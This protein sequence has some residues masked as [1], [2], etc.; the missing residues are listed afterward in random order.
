MSFVNS[1]ILILKIHSSMSEV[2]VKKDPEEIIKKSLEDFHLHNK[3]VDIW[4][5]F[6]IYVQDEQLPWL[7]QLDA[8]D[9]FLS[10]CSYEK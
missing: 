3:L 9:N 10:L 1:F 8:L 2:W 5:D 7:D 6:R 4:L